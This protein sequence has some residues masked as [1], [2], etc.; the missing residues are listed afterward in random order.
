MIAIRRLELD[1]WRALRAVRLAALADSPGNFSA[2]LTDAEAQPDGYWH[3]LLTSRHCAV[4]GLMDGDRLVGITGAFRERS[5][6]SGKTAFFGMTWL[7]PAYRGQ[8]H[9]ALYHRARVDWAREKGF[10]R[11][12]SGHRRSNEPSRRA[13]LRAGFRV[14]GAEPRNWP[15]G[16]QEDDVHYELAL[17]P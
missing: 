10:T 16:V 15:D 14:V 17:A 3:T 8:G 2:S 5:D 1:D 6:P 4:F 12:I 7:D 13:M 11:A 9:A